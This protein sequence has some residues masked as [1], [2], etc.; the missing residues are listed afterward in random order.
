VSH[1]LVAIATAVTGR[2]HYKARAF[3]RGKKKKK[4]KKKVVFIIETVGLLVHCEVG[5]E[6]EETIDHRVY[7]T[8]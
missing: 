8:T 3:R 2:V 4:K 1:T 7:N 6:S 5:T